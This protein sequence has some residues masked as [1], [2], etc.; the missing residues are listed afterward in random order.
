MRA[1]DLSLAAVFKGTLPAINEVGSRHPAVKR[2]DVLVA[3]GKT[4]GGV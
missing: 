4:M 2:Q 3:G 1:N